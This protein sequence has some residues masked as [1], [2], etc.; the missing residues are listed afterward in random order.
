MHLGHA[1]LTLPSRGYLTRAKSR[2]E[3]A[4]KHS[5][6]GCLRDSQAVVKPDCLRGRSLF[7]A[8]FRRHAG[9]AGVCCE[10]GGSL[11]RSGSEMST[12]QHSRAVAGSMSS[13][14]AEASGADVAPQLAEQSKGSR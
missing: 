7:A 5:H 14:T 11:Q 3:N 8:W 10:D 9:A 4:G 2:L 6:L 1:K 13:M 12:S